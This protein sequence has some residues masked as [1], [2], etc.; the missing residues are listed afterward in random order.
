MVSYGA[1]RHFTLFDLLDKRLKDTRAV[2]KAVLSVEM[3]MDKIGVIHVLKPE[4]KCKT[5]NG[6]SRAALRFKFCR[7]FPMPT[8]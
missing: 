1:C 5:Q 2:K 4:V 3:K 6:T 8:R 7:Y